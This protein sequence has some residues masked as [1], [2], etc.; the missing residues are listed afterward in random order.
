MIEPIGQVGLTKEQVLQ[1][2]KCIRHCQIK[3]FLLGYVVS[4]EEEMF[5]SNVV[6]CRCK[7]L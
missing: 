7:M 5:S 4:Q 2:I 6:S 1:N 3:I